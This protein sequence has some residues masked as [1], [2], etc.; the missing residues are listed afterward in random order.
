MITITNEKLKDLENTNYKF[1]RLNS[2]TDI[3]NLMSYLGFLPN[4]WTIRYGKRN[5]NISFYFADNNE[6]KYCRLKE[7]TYSQLNYNDFIMQLLNSDI[8][9]LETDNMNSNNIENILKTLM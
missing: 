2:G 8:L 7:D 4:S 1:K 9:K 6:I 5:E 3:I